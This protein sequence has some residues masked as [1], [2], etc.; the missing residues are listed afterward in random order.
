MGSIN[1]I[2]FFSFPSSG[3]GT[4]IANSFDDSSNQ[5]NSCVRLLILIMYFDVYSTT[6][7]NILSSFL[8]LHVRKMIYI[9]GT[10]SGK[11]IKKPLRYR[12]YFVTLLS[13]AEDYFMI[14]SF[15]TSL[16]LPTT[17]R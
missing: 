12:G 6:L 1:M 10:S 2:C 7:K 13:K 14:L 4:M 15:L 9:D 11:P 8:C 3:L 16:Y 17:R 5:C